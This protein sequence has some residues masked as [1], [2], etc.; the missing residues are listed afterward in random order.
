MFKDST[1]R[2]L[3]A[4]CNTDTWTG[5]VNE[6]DAIGF[7]IGI[8]L[9]DHNCNG[10][11]ISSNKQSDYFVLST[12]GKK[13]TETDKDK[14]DSMRTSI[15]KNC[16]HSIALLSFLAFVQSLHYANSVCYV[17][18]PPNSVIT[19]ETVLVRRSGGLGRSW[20]F[21]VRHHAIFNLP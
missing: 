7:Q 11:K 8:K 19:E 10:P 1:K 17:L 16:C 21:A 6:A 18:A 4:Y 5:L 3:L 14:S 12:T 20:P 9:S 13:M 15:G 2:D